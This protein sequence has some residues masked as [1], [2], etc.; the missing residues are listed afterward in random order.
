MGERRNQGQ[1][2]PKKIK[3]KQLG[4]KEKLGGN[5]KIET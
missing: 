2:T 5:K 3:K 1:K 4:T